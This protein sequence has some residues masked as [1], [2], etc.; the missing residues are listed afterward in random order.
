MCV[1]LLRIDLRIGREEIG[2]REREKFPAHITR[3]SPRLWVES[4]PSCAKTMPQFARV[5]YHNAAMRSSS[6]TELAPAQRERTALS[7]AR[8]TLGGLG[9]KMQ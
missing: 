1:F 4:F 3:P 5:E 2:E 9:S 6:L 7:R 8:C